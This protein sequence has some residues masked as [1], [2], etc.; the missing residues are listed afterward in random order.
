V[1]DVSPTLR[2]LEE[3][4]D[5]APDIYRQ[6]LVVEG[7]CPKPIDAA[8]IE[9]YLTELSDV[10]E[11]RRL[12]D[13]VTHCSATYGWAGW[14]HWE[15]SGAH[16]YAW[17][18]PRLFFSVDIYTCKRFDIESVLHFTQAFFGADEVVSRSF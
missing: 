9:Q 5:L 11:M 10:C 8:Q 1:N 17:D 3:M 12:M 6:R 4:P 13:P 7:R 15:S 18:Q 14:V 2:A 16:M